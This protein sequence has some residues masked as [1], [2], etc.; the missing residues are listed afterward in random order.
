MKNFCFLSTLLI[1]TSYLS[2]CADT[3]LPPL[4][5]T[6]FSRSLDGLKLISEGVEDGQRESSIN[7]HEYEI[8]STSRLL[9]R[10]EDLDAHLSRATGITTENVFVQVRLKGQSYDDIKDAEIKLCPMTRNWMM[11]ATWKRAHP[12][13]G[14][15]LWNEEGGDYDASLCASAQAQTEKNRFVR[16]PD[17]SSDKPLDSAMMVFDVKQWYENYPLSKNEDYGFILLSEAV[18]IKIYGDGSGSD[19]PKIYWNP[20]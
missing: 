11:L 12:Y 6:G 4:D 7:H 1:A 16:F 15:G 17:S 19:R 14:E 8:Q 20:E 3:S 2:G 13:G 18:K 5:D 10:L 9:L